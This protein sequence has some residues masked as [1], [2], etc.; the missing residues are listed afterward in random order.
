MGSPGV[1]S[2]SAWLEHACGGY[3]ALQATG[4][5]LVI[6]E[7]GCTYRH[8]AR[9]NDTV[10][11]EVDPVWASRSSCCVAFRVRRDQIK[12]A[13][14]RSTYVF[15]RNGASAPIPALLDPALADA[16]AQSS[17]RSRWEP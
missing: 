7:N 10:T 8:P 3:L 1:V 14:G 13:D 2:L 11:I 6:I 16:K 12:L 4:G 15:V 5:D 17:C 9:Q